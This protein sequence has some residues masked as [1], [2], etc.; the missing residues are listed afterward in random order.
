[1]IHALIAVP[2]GEISDPDRMKSLIDDAGPIAFAFIVALGVALFF[3]GRSMIRQMKRVDPA[4]PPGPEDAQKAADRQVI[5]D[6]IDRGA[7]APATAPGS[8][9]DPGD[10]A[11]S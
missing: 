3:L 8:E 11:R 7:Q 1:M 6:A 4:L 10:P 5:A 2:L 9:P